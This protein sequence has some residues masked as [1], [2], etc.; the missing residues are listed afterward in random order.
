MHHIFG[1]SIRIDT[2]PRTSE[3]P[4]TIPDAQGSINTKEERLCGPGQRNLD[5]FPVEISGSKAFL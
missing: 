5:H 3:I 2:L 1:L 4:G